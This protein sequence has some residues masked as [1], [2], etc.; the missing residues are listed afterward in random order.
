MMSLSTEGKLR[1]LLEELALIA[2]E[3]LQNEYMA[4]QLKHNINT[5]TATATATSIVLYQDNSNGNGNLNV[6]RSYRRNRE[7]LESTK[8]SSR[9]RK[10]KTKCT[11]SCANSIDPIQL[12][13]SI[14]HV[15]VYPTTAYS[16]SHNKR[17][18]YE[19]MTNS[20]TRS[21]LIR[22]MIRA[23]ILEYPPLLGCSLDRLRRRKD[24]MLKLKISWDSIVTIIR[25]TDE[26]HLRW[27]EKKCR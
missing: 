2:Q 26:A 3:C 27:M 24:D 6:D 5:A 17:V 7:R 20:T 23:K 22:H 16:S 15:P 18:L 25:R 12:K 21:I 10:K 9:T 19:A 13:Y 4:Y 11:N 1:D 8:K 14:V